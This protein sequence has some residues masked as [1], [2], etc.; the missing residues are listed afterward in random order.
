MKG[1]VMARN[2][3]ANAAPTDA[4]TENAKPAM[5][6]S[7][8]ATPEEHIVTPGEVNVPEEIKAFVN[9]G[10]EFWQT[11]PKKWRSVLLPN[12]D[13]VK[14]VTNKSRAFAKA[15]GRTFRVNKQASTDVTLVY[16]VT[17][18][19]QNQGSEAAPNE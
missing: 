16:K 14:F 4:P 17:D 9:A 7:A 1:K 2:T 5:D 13:A 3:P 10:H 19:F 15:T 18:K 8:L 11:K 12:A 6:L